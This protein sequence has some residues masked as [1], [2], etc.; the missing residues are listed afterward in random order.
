MKVSALTTDP[1]VRLAIESQIKLGSYHD[2]TD[3]VIK[4][5]LEKEGLPR[6]R[7]FIVEPVNKFLR[8]DLG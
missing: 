4:G 8:G 3:G 5:A 6:E 2:G 1:N 7:R